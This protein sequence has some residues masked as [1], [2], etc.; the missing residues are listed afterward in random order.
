[1]NG[2]QIQ[3]PKATLAAYFGVGPSQEPKATFKFGADTIKTKFTH[4]NNN[5]HRLRL[6]PLRDIERPAIV[7]FNRIGLNEY[8]CTLV[9]K[10]DYTNVLAQ[11]CAQQ[12][13]SSARK[14]GLE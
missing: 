12:T 14:W 2:Y 8:K 11:K 5:T 10:A 9:P 7:I 6:M 4:F 3:L 13:R 1:M